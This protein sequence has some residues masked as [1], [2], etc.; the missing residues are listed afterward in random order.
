MIIPAMAT[1]S[2]HGQVAG[3]PQL[4]VP[5]W[6]YQSVPSGVTLGYTINSIP[7]LSFT[8]NPIGVNQMLLVNMWHTYTSGENRFLAAYTV[9]ITKPDGTQDV[10][11]LNSY[12]ADSTAWFNYIP[13]ELGTYQLQ[14]TFPGEYFPQ[15]WYYNGILLTNTTT[16]TVITNS[17]CAYY[18]SN[19]WYA[20]DQTAV[21]NLTVQQSPIISWPLTLPTDYWSRPIEPNNRG[22]WSIAGNYPWAAAN[23]FAQSATSNNYM[24]PYVTPPLTPHIV[25][26]AV[27][28]MSGIIGGEAGQNANVVGPSSAGTANTPSVIYMGRCYTTVTKS[29]YGG[30]PQTYAECYD[31]QTGQIYYDIA[32]ANGGITPTHIAYWAGTDTS[33]P[34]AAADAAYGVELNTIVGTSTSARLYKINPVNGAI[35]ANITLPSFGTGGIAEVGYYNGYYLS[36]QNSGPSTFVEVNAYLINWT[37]QGGSS[38]AA[39]ATAAQIASAFSTRIVSNI[40]ITVGLQNFKQLGEPSAAQ[41]LLN[42]YDPVSGIGVIQN[43]YLY[44]GVYGTSLIGINY[45]TGQQIWNYTSSSSQET[46]SSPF[47]MA[48]SLSENGMYFAYFEQGFWKAFNIYTG[49]IV[50][51]TQINDYPWGEF[52]LYTC[53]SYNG[54]LYA[55]GY[56]GVWALN[57]T[58]GAIIWHYADPA[59]P[60]ETP[61]TSNGTS[62]YSMDEIKSIGGLLFVTNDE[63]TPTLPPERG[64]GLNCLNA[65]TGALEWKIMGTRMLVAAASDGYLIAGSNYD[66]TVYTL[67]KGPSATTVSV[68]QTQITAGTTAVISGIVLDKSPAQP[69][70]PC[71]SDA[72]MATWM[73]YLHL[74]MPINGIYGNATITGVPVSLY[75]V[76][77]SGNEVNIAT[78]TSNIDGSFGCDWT[79]TTAGNYTIYAV[80]A[81]TDSYGSS[82]AAAYAYVSQA[83]TTTVTPTPTVS[84]AQAQSAPDY[85]MTIIATGIAVII[86]VAIVGFLMLRKRP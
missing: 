60:F 1:E 83:P 86:A 44:G 72:S 34:G 9:T 18:P 62:V 47:N 73:D 3:T 56:T 42:S 14:F 23:S 54:M 45:L 79:P 52:E 37:E 85:T 68:P 63:H 12:V 39:T 67:G 82:S 76:G 65:T 48:T 6:A 22:W 74:Q 13:S 58:N 32:T 24:G 66:G 7:F 69:G 27:S 77:P 25:W 59:M 10:I 15:G 31:L 57:E 36:Y 71:I 43:R 35:T 28:Q 50:W 75:A 81:G 84:P 20:P 70:T 40:S 19:E 51:T 61:Y 21:Q 26:S 17:T 53:A 8:P 38:T 46:G 49:Q 64:W 16:S 29:L 78:V 33:V 2:N 41:S 5:N 80:F 4:V 11:T 55:I 30:S